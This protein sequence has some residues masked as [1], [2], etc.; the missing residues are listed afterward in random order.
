MEIETA[1]EQLGA[2]FCGDGTLGAVVMRPNRALRRSEDRKVWIQAAEEALGD[3]GGCRPEWLAE[4]SRARL[5]ADGVCQDQDELEAEEA[6]EHA[7]WLNVEW[8]EARSNG[9]GYVLCRVSGSGESNVIDTLDAGGPD[10]F[11][12]REWP[13]ALGWDGRADALRALGCPEHVLEHKYTRLLLDGE[14]K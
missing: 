4:A 7:T 14:E 2:V 13:S 3:W 9:G 6:A 12:P 10:G 8:V 11:G 5:D 1:S